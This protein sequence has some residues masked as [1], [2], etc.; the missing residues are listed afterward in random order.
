MTGCRLKTRRL[1]LLDP[2]H[3]YLLEQFLNLLNVKRLGHVPIHAGLHAGMMA[4]AAFG[5]VFLALA[6]ISLK[7]IGV[8]RVNPAEILR[9]E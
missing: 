2:L 9:R 8:L 1:E 4:A 5:V 3:L 7:V 6:T